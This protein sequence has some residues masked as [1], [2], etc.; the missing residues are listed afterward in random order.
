MKHWVKGMRDAFFET[1]FKIAKKDKDVI[2]L[3]AD[4]GAICHDNFREKLKQQYFNVGIA[5]QNMMGVAAGLAMAGKTVY[6]YGIIPFI[7]ARCLEQIK[8]DICGMNLSVNLVGIGAG[9][10][11]SNLGATHY[12]IDDI[13]MM[14]CL[15]NLKIYSSSDNIM[16]ASL[17]RFSYELK[18]PKY[19]RLDRTGFPL[20]YR[21]KKRIDMQKGFNILRKSKQLY[22]ISTGRIIY[23]SLDIVKMLKKYSID[24][25]MIDLFAIK[26]VNY[27]WLFDLLR[28][29][30]YVV[31]LEE[32]ILS[33]GLGESIGMQ[34]YRTANSFKFKAIGLEN[35]N[36]SHFISRD[37]ARQ[38]NSIDAFA[39]AREI[40]EWVNS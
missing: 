15:A 36:Y 28:E 5:E 29:V 35:R 37:F 8:V 18:G 7:T 1:L 25:G 24:A 12:G 9:F 23:S 3:T 38:E 34:A 31:T 22:I 19:I 11:Y 39:V 4:T 30:K 17:A 40:R 14:K 13:A 16:A 32:H 2:L 21:N 26:P 33:G 6:V 27:K 10:D 20:V